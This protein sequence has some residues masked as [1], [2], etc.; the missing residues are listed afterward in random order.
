VGHPSASTG[1][2]GP[3]RDPAFGDHVDA[4]LAGWAHERPD[5]DVS[6]LAVV[7]RIGRLAAYFAA[8]ID[9]IFARAGLNSS[10]FAILANLCRSGAPY[11]LTQR[12]LM[13]SLRLTSGTI[14]VR[15][16]HLSERGLVT[17]TSDPR[18]GRSVLVTMTG[19]GRELFDAIAPEHLRNEAR[20]VS[21]L[22]PEAR[23]QLAA[24]LRTLLIEFDNPAQGRPDVRLGLRVTP[25]HVAVERRAA[26][27]LPPPA[28]LLIESSRSDGW[29]GSAGLTTGDV[30]VKAGDRA[31][32]S[33]ACLALALETSRSTVEFT[34]QR[35]DGTF[36]VACDLAALSTF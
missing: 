14:S 3:P 20:L 7:Q 35:R 23:D 34:V 12:H 27:G 21:G 36:T 17:R 11:R 29:A 19:A 1:G 13:D 33:L 15:I 32:H 28:G 8:E 4:L 22:P 18:D 24:L 26:V 5:L 6:P 25:T 16:D 10:D 9:P 31:L 30:L 2:D